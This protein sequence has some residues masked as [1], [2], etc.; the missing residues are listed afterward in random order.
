MTESVKVRRVFYGLLTGSVAEAVLLPAMLL[1]TERIAH[2][3]VSVSGNVLNTENKTTKTE[4]PT[5]SGTKLHKWFLIFT[6]FCFFFSKPTRSKLVFHT[7]V[8]PAW[9]RGK[10]GSDAEQVAPLF[11]YMGKQTVSSLKN[12]WWNFSERLSE[13]STQENSW[14]FLSENLPHVLVLHFLCVEIFFSYGI[15]WRANN[16][17]PPYTDIALSVICTAFL[18]VTKAFF[19]Y[20]LYSSLCYGCPWKKEVN[21]WINCNSSLQPSG[22]RMCLLCVEWLKLA[23]SA[24]HHIESLWCF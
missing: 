10:V 19:P 6:V 21:S 22:R 15:Y 9:K 18:R 17:K 24:D 1:K 14:S 2:Q 3:P 11:G 20:P 23:F 7:A 5:F 12:I 8:S 4:F 16:S 13:L